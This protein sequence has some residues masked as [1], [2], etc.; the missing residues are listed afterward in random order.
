MPNFQIVNSRELS[1]RVKQ[2]TDWN[3]AQS[4]NSF[5]F[6]IFILQRNQKSK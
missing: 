2:S 4:F 6:C 5:L 1:I 3:E